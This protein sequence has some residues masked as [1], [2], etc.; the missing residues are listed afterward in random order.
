MALLTVLKLNIRKSLSG[1][2]LMILKGNYFNPESFNLAVITT[3]FLLN[4]LDAAIF[5]IIV[6]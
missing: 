6:L 1:H 4:I 2:Q 5:Y 3:A